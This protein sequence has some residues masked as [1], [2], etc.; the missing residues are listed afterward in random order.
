[1][2]P[3]CSVY[4]TTEDLFVG[5]VIEIAN[6]EKPEAE[7][8]HLFN[9]S[10]LLVRFRVQERFRGATDSVVEV[11]TGRGGGDCGYPFKVGDIYLVYAS[12]NKDNGILYTGICSRTRPLEKAGED[13]DFLRSLPNQPPGAT[14]FG[15]VTLQEESSKGW[16]RTP[17]A[18]VGV[19]ISGPTTAKAITDPN[20]GYKFHS[21][22]PGDYDVSF[23]LAESYTG[24]PSKVSVA[25]KACAQVDEY[26]RQAG[27]ISGRVL[28]ADG[29][30]VANVVVDLR[31]DSKHRE[32]WERPQ[33]DFK[34]TDQDGHYKFQELSPGTY[35]AGVNIAFGPENK[36]PFPPTFY[37]GIRD[38]S[39][40][41]HLGFGQRFTKAD[42]QLPPRLVEREV[43]VVATWPDG[44]RVEGALLSVTGSADL[45]YH[46]GPQK[47]EQN[48]DAILLLEGQKYY[49]GAYVNLSNGKQKCAEAVEVTPSTHTEPVKLVIDHD[50]GACAS[51]RVK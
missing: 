8:T 51:P 25:D 50:G 34:Q 31:Y 33:L 23:A 47:S 49:V 32:S 43:P 3:A 42:I 45:N 22:S 26:P 2:K 20:G 7:P 19:S 18:G 21:L 9:F 28:D 39:Q 30:P 4:S 38:D 11:S 27:E 13:M 40:P 15:T 37:P 17:M 5:Q 16:Q 12:R 41:I 36:T 48:P 35:V 46:F 29:K 6:R 44:R 14:I 10:P 1:V 24:H